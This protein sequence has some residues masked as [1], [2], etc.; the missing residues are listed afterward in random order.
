MRITDRISVLL[1]KKKHRTVCID[2]RLG[3]EAVDEIL[4]ELVEHF[5][6]LRRDDRAENE[7][8]R[9]ELE[10]LRAERD[11]LRPEQELFSEVDLVREQL[12][13]LFVIQAKWDVRGDDMR[14]Q[15]DSMQAELEVLR[16][17]RD[18]LR[19]ASDALL[20]ALRGDGSGGV[21]CQQ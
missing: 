14:A 20:A 17:E 9:A 8:L 4:C 7:K 1:E 19:G 5:E 12:R 11:A 18:A 16:A 6:E 13:D 3:G 10:V 21:G 2:V 15:L